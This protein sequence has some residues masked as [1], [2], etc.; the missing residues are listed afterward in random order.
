M[1]V[2]QAILRSLI[3]TMRLATSVLAAAMLL[4]VQT[5]I[6][7][8]PQRKSRPRAG[9]GDGPGIP[10]A[11]CTSWAIYHQWRGAVGYPL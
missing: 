5:L 7:T 11:P 2:R 9:Q 4:C 6:R 10:S 1:Q 8:T 3:A